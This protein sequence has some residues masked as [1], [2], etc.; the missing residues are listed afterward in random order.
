[1]STIDRLES[2]DQ[3]DEIRVGDLKKIKR[4]LKRDLSKYHKRDNA[5]YEEKGEKEDD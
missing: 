5:A 3:L 2:D 1:M 4:A